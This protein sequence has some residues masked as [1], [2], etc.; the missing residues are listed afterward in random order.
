MVFQGYALFPHR[1]VRGNIGYS[2]SVRHLP[3]AEIA[4]RVDERP[5]LVRLA[6]IGQRMPGQLSGG[7]KQRVALAR[8]L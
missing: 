8:A 6:E 3:R 1:T 5:D 2:L 7:Q 4:A